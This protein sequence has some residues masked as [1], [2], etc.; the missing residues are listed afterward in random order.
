MCGACA[1]VAP[2]PRVAGPRRRAAAA[3]AVT[4]ATGVRVDVAVGVWAVR[5]ATG[6]QQVCVTVEEL[7]DA[8]ARTTGADPAAVADVAVRAAAE[9]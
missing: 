2:D 5:G 6:R 8:V 9:V 1:H 4:A 7:A 3:A